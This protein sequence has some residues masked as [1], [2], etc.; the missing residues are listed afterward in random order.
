MKRFLSVLTVLV[1][2]V[3]GFAVKGF[4]GDSREGLTPELIKKLEGSFEL[5]PQTRALINAV[6]NNDLKEL[7]FDRE[8]H[9]RHD[10]L[11]SIKIETEGITDQKSSGRCWLFAGFNMMRPAVMEKYNLSEFKFSENYLF[12]WDKLE[13]ANTF[14][15]AVIE[16]RDRDIDDREL[17]ALLKNPVPDGGWWNYAVDL[18]EKYGAVPKSL[19]PET[20]NTSN[21]R[22]MN[23]QLNKMTRSFAARI[24]ENASKGI[25]EAELRAGKVEML[26]KVYRLLV[27]NMGFPPEEFT[28]RVE[29][30]DGKIFE[31]NYTPVSFYKEAVE[32]DLKEYICLL[33]HP[34]YEYDKLYRIRYCRNLSD[35][36]DME[37]INVEIG[38]LRKYALEAVLNDEPVWFA[39]D[40]GKA[41]DTKNGIL[42]SG[43][44]DIASLLGT[45]AG[46]TKA[47]RVLYRESVPGHAM[48]FIGADLNDDTPKKWLVE[49]SWGKDTGNDGLWTMYD[50][51]FG[52]YVYSVIVHKRHVPKDVLKIL[53]TEPEILPAW[54]P[55]RGAFD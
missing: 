28:W 38:K 31:K 49:N 12:F 25:S 11:F 41:N 48:V 45:E 18:I 43:A 50:E 39:A 6:S 8:F 19:M 53:K 17:Q 21:T 2:L 9:S 51:W 55:M 20:K 26:E 7:S 42:A 40:V 36:S 16:T 13:K 44:Y 46:M 30:K 1:V 15:E 37:F 54:D 34:V 24:R 33:D 27:L 22:R 29:N 3:S 14:L 23:G 47:Q 4:G 32:V 35:H 5:N 52:K 10:D